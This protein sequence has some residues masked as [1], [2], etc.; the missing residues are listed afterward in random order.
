[1]RTKLIRISEKDLVR[2]KAYPLDQQEAPIYYWYEPYTGVIEIWPRDLANEYEL[3]IT[4][5]ERH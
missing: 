4:I 5:E 2:H 3:S 1:M